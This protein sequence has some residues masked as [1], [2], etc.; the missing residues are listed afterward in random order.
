MKLLPLVIALLLPPSSAEGTALLVPSHTDG[1]MLKCRTYDLPGYVTVVD[2]EIIRDYRGTGRDTAAGTEVLPQADDLISVEVRCLRVR[3]TEKESGWALR[4]AIVV[5][6]KS[7][8][9][10][11][12]HAQLTELV[13]EQ[14]LHFGRT[15]RYAASLAELKFTDTRAALGIELKLHDDGWSASVSFKDPELGCRVAVG[16]AAAADQEL[17]PGIPEC[18][19]AD[20]ARG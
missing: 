7:G 2:G 19:S 8:A 4:S 9:P 16:G 17:R 5:V 11:V 18:V 10:K 3:S 1:E 15:G 20:A 14:R 12:A 13:E 6:T